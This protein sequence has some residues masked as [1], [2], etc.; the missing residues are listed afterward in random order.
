M[1]TALTRVRM[2]PRREHQLAAAFVRA[3]S[4]LWRE[5]TRE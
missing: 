3:F 5:R 1:D 2:A 4:I